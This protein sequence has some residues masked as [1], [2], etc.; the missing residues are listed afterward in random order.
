MLYFFTDD[1]V[2]ALQGLTRVPGPVE[3]L[4][5][6]LVPDRVTD[7]RRCMSFASSI[8]ELENGSW[9]MYYSVMN[10]AT[11]LRGIAVAESTDGL[12]WH[13][14]DLGQ[15]HVDGR[16]TNRLTIKGLPKGVTRYAQ[17]QVNQ[18]DD[19]RW[20]MY[21]WVNQRPY[22][23]Y[24]VAESEDGL[25][26]QVEHFDRPVIYHPLELGSWI[27]SPGAA[28]GDDETAANVETQRLDRFVPSSTAEPNWGTTVDCKSPDGLL[29]LKGLRSNDAT[30]VYHDART[31]QY[32]YYAP[33][34]ICNPTGSPRRVENDNAPFMLRAIHR[35]TSANGLSWGD[36]QLIVV[37]DE[38]DPIDQQFYYLAIHRQDDWHIGLLGSYL[39]REQTMDI[40]L[41]F[42][43]DGVRWDRPIRTPWL[44]HGPSGSDDAA[45]VYA[46]NRLIDQGDHWLMLYTASA[47][48]HNELRATDD[49]KVRASVCAARLAKGR[50]LALTT[51]PGRTGQVWTKPFILGGRELCIDAHIEGTLRAELCDPFGNALAGFERQECRPVTGDN[52]SRPLQWRGKSTEH[53]CYNAVSL[54]LEIDHGRIYSIHW[55]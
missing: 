7:G 39:V 1:T 21:F 11:R 48:R 23:R 2:N 3:K 42:S 50:F 14:P 34:P 26:W 29:R 35:R 18:T 9:R 37:P 22:L 40:E 36:P 27:W 10:L 28:P 20:R 45:M 38:D 30:Y 47:Q 51:Q 24:V 5:P 13:K 43:G 19:G 4:G 46:P 8:V 25:H 12:S 16:D 32:T 15:M 55:R 49:A 44:P 54:K 17:P 6:V 52:T 53:Y 41:C 31:G 33:W